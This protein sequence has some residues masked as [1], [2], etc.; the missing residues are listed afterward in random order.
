MTAYY[1]ERYGLSDDFIKVPDHALGRPD[2]FG[3]VPC[4]R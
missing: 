1:D 4:A 3:L 2:P